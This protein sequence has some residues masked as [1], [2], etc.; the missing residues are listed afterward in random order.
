M[1]TRSAGR[2]F[3]LADRAGNRDPFHGHQIRDREM[4]ADAEHQQDDADFRELTRDGRIGRESRRRRTDHDA[5]EQVSD[6]R[7][8]PQSRR[9]ESKEKRRGKSERERDKE[10]RLM[11]HPGEKL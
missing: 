1:R 6:K 4:Q 5:G 7:R 9:D 3:H 8:K 11:V 2:P 10:R